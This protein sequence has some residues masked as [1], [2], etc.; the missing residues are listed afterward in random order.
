MSID[1]SS[2]HL[3]AWLYDTPMGAA[4][5]EI[6][7]R[8]LTG[9]QGL[10]VQDEITVSWVPGTHEPR[11][12]HLRHQ[13][14]GAGSHVPHL[15]RP[16]RPTVGATLRGSVLGALA[17]AL[18]LEPGI[19]QRAETGTDVEALA[20]RVREIGIDEEFL[21]QL[22]RELVPGHS[23]LMVLASDVDLDVVGP[24]VEHGLARGDVTRV[25]ARVRDDTREALRVLLDVPPD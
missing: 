15:G 16:R 18:V 19:G 17:G 8:D 7:L 11:V 13:T 12:G 24:A 5:G 22:K 23:A 14:A 21:H 1:Q 20:Q 2:T 3:S 4:A 10:R 25:Y 9:R 6:R